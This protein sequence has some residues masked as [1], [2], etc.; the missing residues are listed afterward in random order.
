[1][2]REVGELVAKA[3]K[4]ELTDDALRLAPLLMGLFGKLAGLVAVVSAGIYVRDERRRRAELVAY[5]VAIAGGAWTAYAWLGLPFVRHAGARHG[6]AAWLGSPGPDAVAISFTGLIGLA[7][8]A[9]GGVGA[10]A[11]IARVLG[12][13]PK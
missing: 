11:L 10:C 13:K 12:D 7:A 1:M 5:L 2:G 4:G 9:A 6:W 3:V 8:F